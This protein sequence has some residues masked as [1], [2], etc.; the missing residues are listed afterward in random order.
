VSPRRS[1]R[2][3]PATVNKAE[4]ESL[5]PRSGSNRGQSKPK[6]KAKVEKEPESPSRRSSRTRAAKPSYAEKNSDDEEWAE[7]DPSE[8]SDDDVSSDEEVKG[9]RQKRGRSGG[10]GAP[11]AKKSRSGYQYYPDL[12]SIFAVDSMPQFMFHAYLLFSRLFP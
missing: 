1:T 11:A 3:K 9:K 6:A 8:G 5:I 4:S 7:H 10:G 2:S 12:V